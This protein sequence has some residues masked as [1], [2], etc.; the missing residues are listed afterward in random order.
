MKYFTKGLDLG[1]LRESDIKGALL[2]AFKD[3]ASVGAIHEQLLDVLAR[4][5]SA[6]ESTIAD[7]R[8]Q[9]VQLKDAM[10]HCVA[11]LNAGLRAA[12]IAE[13]REL[14]M[15]A[16]G[17]AAGAR[18]AKIHGNQFCP[19]GSGKKYKKCCAGSA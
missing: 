3:L 19:C 13:A 8:S 7:V 11:R 12:R 5:T 4:D 2:A 14:G 16:G 1:G 6:Q 15:Q 9:V 10:L 18:P 17:K